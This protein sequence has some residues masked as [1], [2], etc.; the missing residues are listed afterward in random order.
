MSDVE[1][2]FGTI[3]AMLA[4]QPRLQRQL[5]A[6]SGDDYRTSFERKY[7]LAGKKIYQTAY[8]AGAMLS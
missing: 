5:E 2:Y 6:S 8:Q 1:E 4:K 7:R 3:T